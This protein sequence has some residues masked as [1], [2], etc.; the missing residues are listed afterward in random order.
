MM[1][2]VLVTDIFG[3]SEALQQLANDL[4]EAKVLIVDPYAGKVMDFE[5]ELL[6]YQYFS[7]NVGLANYAQQLLGKLQTINQP[8]NL[9]AF[10]VGGSATWLNADRLSNTKVN[11][12]TCFYPSQIRHHLEQKLASP[13]EVV[14]PKSEPHFNIA[15]LRQAL[16]CKE[17]VIITQSNA[18]H[19]F[20][21][22]L[23]D[24]YSYATYQTYLKWL[25]TK[26]IR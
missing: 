5:N 25:I 4:T 8:F 1:L 2:T 9:I 17:N 26:K 16:I 23:S 18:L 15:E 14:L 3:D 24:N 20:M 11:S 6:A 12:A 21:N 19:G 22:L 7:D 13:I 10:S